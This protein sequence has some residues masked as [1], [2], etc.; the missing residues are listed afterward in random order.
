MESAMQMQYNSQMEKLKIPEYG[1][2]IQQLVEHAVTI[3]D[4][5]TRQRAAEQ[6]VELMR[7]VT[8]EPKNQVETN[9]KL[10]NHLFIIS[11]Y[12]LDVLPPSGV[13]PEPGTLKIEPRVIPYP[14]NN[15][16]RR[17]YGKYI[18]VLIEKAVTI[19]DKDRQ[20][21]LLETVAAYM[22]VSYTSWNQDPFVSDDVVISDLN[23][24]LKG[25]VTLP[26]NFSIKVLYKDV[27]KKNH[28]HN[29]KDKKRRKSGSKKHSYR[30]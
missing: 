1:R 6:I 9:D 21:A 10:W 3:E 18:Q 4:K 7:M 5:E 2:H 24:M 22:R 13:K 14:Q 28:K 30:K 26:D 19:D 29:N 11:D 23:A 15:S 16:S 27:P 25:R 17:H 12:K 20:M 8:G